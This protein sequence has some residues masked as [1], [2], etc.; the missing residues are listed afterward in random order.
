MKSKW[1]PEVDEMN[2]AYNSKRHVR[3]EVLPMPSDPT[4]VAGLVRMDDER[5][6]L[7]GSHRS[8]L[9]MNIEVARSLAH[10][11]ARERGADVI[12]IYDPR[13]LYPTHKRMA[14]R[15]RTFPVHVM[16][17]G[18]MA[19]DLRIDAISPEVAALVA[20]GGPLVPECGSMSNLACEVFDGT[21]RIMFYWPQGEPVVG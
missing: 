5:A 6:D 18:K 15:M 9:P 7:P 10:K 8:S 19:S 13:G 11:V 20:C 4:R 16:L 12:W 21:K 14:G 1:I 2:D 3:L 17:G